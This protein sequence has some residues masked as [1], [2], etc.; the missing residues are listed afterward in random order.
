VRKKIRIRRLRKDEGG[1]VLSEIDNYVLMVLEKCSGC[2]TKMD[3]L[4]LEA[5]SQ[6]FYG[7]D[8]Q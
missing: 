7:Y 6:A 1:E 5:M 3:G 2:T 4:N 8:V